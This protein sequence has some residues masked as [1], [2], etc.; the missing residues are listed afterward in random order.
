MAHWLFS[1]QYIYTGM[2]LPALF[3]QAKI[4]WFQEGFNDSGEFDF[5]KVSGLLEDNQTNKN[6][7][8]IEAFK[9]CD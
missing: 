8:M 6:G 9:K 1:A 5:S 4:E 3:T 7:S 2:I